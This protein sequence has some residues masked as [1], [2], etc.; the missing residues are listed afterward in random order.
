MVLRAKWLI[1]SWMGGQLHFC[2]SYIT[3]MTPIHSMFF[4]KYPLSLF[5]KVIYDFSGG[6][7]PR[8]TNRKSVSS[9][10]I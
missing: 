3:I 1:I 6:F 4:T 2:T 5:Y 8:N 7:I 9:C 10:D